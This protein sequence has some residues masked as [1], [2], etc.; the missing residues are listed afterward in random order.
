MTSELTTMAELNFDKNDVASIAIAEAEVRMRQN[1]KNLTAQIA[2]CDHAIQKTKEEIEKQGE[3]L[4][5]QKI[6][7]TVKRIKS[8]LKATKVKNFCVEVETQ[9]DVYSSNNSNKYDPNNYKISAVLYKDKEKV[10]GRLTLES[11]C[12]PSNQLQKTAQKNLAVFESQ[13]SNLTKE[14]LEWRKK[15]GDM[16]TL[17]RQIKAALARRQIESTKE[18]KALI[19]GLVKNFDNTVKLLGNL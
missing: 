2:D 11:D 17:E 19:Q 12:L 1:I 13:K 9:V 14:A 6:A 10:V 15:L 7:A 3:I 8:G 16:P 18:G 4:I 5:E